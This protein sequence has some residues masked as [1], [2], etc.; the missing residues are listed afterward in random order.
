MSAPVTNR[1]L[2]I[3]VT[4]TTTIEVPAGTVLRRVLDG[5]GAAMY[6]VE[7]PFAFVAQ[8]DWAARHDLTHYY[9]WVPA[10]AV[11]IKP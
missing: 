11:E 7:D 4:R 2:R 3:E 5:T 9:A 1:A 6:A 10:D 8:G